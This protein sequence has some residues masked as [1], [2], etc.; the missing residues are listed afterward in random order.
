MQLPSVEFFIFHCW[1]LWVQLN[2]QC[3]RG[4]SHINASLRSMFEIHSDLPT[5]QPP[6]TLLSMSHLLHNLLDRTAVALFLSFCVC[7]CVCVCVFVCVCVCVCVCVYLQGWGYGSRA[8]DSGLLYF[9]PF[10]TKKWI[11]HTYCIYCIYIQ[12]I[13]TYTHIYIYTVYDNHSFQAL[14]NEKSTKVDS[15]N[16][17]I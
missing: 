5:Q 7:V 12:Y 15:V 1:L 8:V 13:F 16:I 11:R 17:Y 2:V 6:F 9:V 10:Q 3:S 4:R 14:F